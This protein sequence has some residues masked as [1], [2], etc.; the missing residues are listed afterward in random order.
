[1]PRRK[2]TEEFVA[3]V[4]AK[5]P[6]INVIEE[7]VNDKTPILLYCNVCGT[8]WKDLPRYILHSSLGCPECN[9]KYVNVGEN[10]FATKAPHLIQ[11][12]KDQS[13]AS[14]TTYMSHKLIELI[15]PICGAE[16]T[17]NAF[18][19]YREGFHCQCC[20]DGVS[21]PNRLIRNVMNS[22]VVDK[23][24]FEY[25]DAWTNGKLYDVY[26]EINNNK[27]VIEMDGAQHYN[28]ARGSSWTSYEEN[29]KNDEEKDKLAEKNNVNMI[30]INCKISRFSYIKKNIIDSK[31]H[32]LFDF[33]LIDW[34]ECNR[35][36]QKSIILDVCEY[37]N[38]HHCSITEITEVFDLHNSTVRSY[39]IKG[40]E[41]G[42]CSF[43][44]RD[45][46][47]KPVTAYCLSS[48]NSYNF[49]SI[50]ECS[51]YLTKLF[52]CNYFGSEIGRA[53]KTGKPYKG[54]IFNQINGIAS[55]R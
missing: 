9:K 15:C 51:T 37:Y 35:Q 21:Y 18:D 54:F 48:C 4:S 14:K 5:H 28:I 26:F 45:T 33:S 34:D 2:T 50:E 46:Q 52:D 36:S 41:L 42:L 16:R 23:I 7:Y 12:F 31:L 47:R 55:S 32:E 38:K 19:L 29:K 17:M 40:N 22:F 1:M 30:R 13:E 24:K 3:D 25:C 11:F 43:K 49:Q 27:Y 53:C 8:T 20:G 6:T 39:L 44:I 10:D